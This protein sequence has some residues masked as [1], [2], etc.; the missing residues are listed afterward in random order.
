[1]N[2]ELKKYWDKRREEWIADLSKST[3]EGYKA[4]RSM[5][6]AAVRRWWCDNQYKGMPGSLLKDGMITTDKATISEILLKQYAKVSRGREPEWKEWP[7]IGRDEF[8][9]EEVKAAISKI[10]RDTAPGPENTTGTMLRELNERGLKELTR[11]MNRVYREGK[12]PETWKYATVSAIHKTGKLRVKPESYRPISLTPLLYR[13]YGRLLKKRLEKATKRFIP[14]E[15]A[16]F[17]PERDVVQQIQYIVQRHQEGGETTSV[18]LDIE[19]AYDTVPRDT[20]MD[21]LQGMGVEAHLIRAIQSTLQETWISVKG[22]KSWERTN[23]GVKQGCVLAPTLFVLFMANWP[24]LVRKKHMSE[25]YDIREPPVE[26]T[27]T[28]DPL[29]AV[30]TMFVD[31]IL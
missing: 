13:V 18:F 6:E 17:Q 29:P 20:L 1:M 19:K 27:S 12:I 2:S 5:V 15:Q 7:G 21:K 22:A 3:R 25:P 4:S 31:D 24:H 10:K 23:R 9:K 28:R 16:G 14:R 11:F 8:S 30:L 26:T